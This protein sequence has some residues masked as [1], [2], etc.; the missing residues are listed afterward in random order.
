MRNNSLIVANLLFL[1]MAGHSAGAT[2]MEFPD[3]SYTVG[4]IGPNGIGCGTIN[5]IDDRLT[6][7]TPHFD[8]LLIDL[9][10]SLFPFSGDTFLDIQVHHASGYRFDDHDYFGGAFD[11]NVVSIESGSFQFF[12]GG[13]ALGFEER[14]PLLIGEAR[15]L[16]LSPVGNGTTAIIEL[17]YVAPEIAAIIGDMTSLQYNFPIVPWPPGEDVRVWQD[18]LLEIADICFTSG[19]YM[20]FFDEPPKGESPLTFSVA[21]AVNSDDYCGNGDSA[22]LAVALTYTFDASS[23]DQSNDPSEG[24]YFSCQSSYRTYSGARTQIDGN[25]KHSPCVVV[26]VR[27]DVLVEGSTVDQYVVTPVGRADVTGHFLVLEDASASMLSDDSLPLVPPVAEF[28][29]SSTPIQGQ[30]ELEIQGGCQINSFAGTIRT[31]GD[32]DSDGR[33][34]FDDNCTLISNARQRDSDGD[35]FGNA[36]DPDLNN[37]GLVSV[38]DLGLFRASFFDQGNAHADFDSDGKVT[39]SD[40]GILRQFFFSEPGPSGIAP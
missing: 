33:P 39:F 12:G 17:T 27:N 37:D 38:I 13:G 16:Q 35:G 3:P 10:N 18:E 30:I 40:L 29:E 5:F 25:S 21:T 8:F 31:V 1:V 32:Q 20:S 26:R 7:L 11:P 24:V 9:D 22:D 4:R 19:P 28:F 6:I 2:N 34:D 14:R 23:L 36:C 15:S